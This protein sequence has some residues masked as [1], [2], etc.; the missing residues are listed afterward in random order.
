MAK[1]KDVTQQIFNKSL[2]NISSSTD[3]CNLLIE[4]L[5]SLSTASRHNII[6]ITYVALLETY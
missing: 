1:Y 2:F 6:T 4:L 3:L 5:I